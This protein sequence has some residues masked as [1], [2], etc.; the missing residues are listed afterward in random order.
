M[1]E[2]RVRKPVVFVGS[3]CLAVFMDRNREKA[4]FKEIA[5]FMLILL[6]IVA[7]YINYIIFF[8]CGLKPICYK[9]MII[10]RR[11]CSV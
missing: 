3:W 5:R 1:Y 11:Y 6:K 9:T 2:M 8:G 7:K 4:T 10:S